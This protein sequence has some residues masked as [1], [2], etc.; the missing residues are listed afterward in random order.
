MSRCAWYATFRGPWSLGVTT[1]FAV[2][3]FLFAPGPYAVSGD[4]PGGDTPKADSTAPRGPAAVGDGRREWQ[5]PLLP[6]YVVLAG[7]TFADA[8]T[9]WVVG[10]GGTILKTTDAGSHWVQLNSGT[11]NDLKTVV[12]FDSQMG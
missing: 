7:V 5:N 1:I 12:F 9:G 3:A 2:L 4:G 8:L 6:S 10:A 11:S